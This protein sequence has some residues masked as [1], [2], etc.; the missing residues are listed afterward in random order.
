[1]PLK[2]IVLLLFYFGILRHLVYHKGTFICRRLLLTQEATPLIEL[3]FPACHES[4]Q[5]KGVTHQL[6]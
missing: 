5:T 6:S 1:M 3:L 4:T 2:A